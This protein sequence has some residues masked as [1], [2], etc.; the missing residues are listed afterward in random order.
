MKVSMEN[1]K[2]E[3]IKRM[4]A[5]DIYAEAIRH[6]AYDGTLN[7]SEPPLGM[8][9]WL[10][11]KQKEIVKKFEEEYNALVYFGI[12]SYT[13]FGTWDSFLFV[14][15]YKEEWE[16]DNHIIKDGEV[17]AYVYNYD[18]PEYSEMG[19]IGVQQIFGGLVRIW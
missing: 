17:Y 19:C 8:N 9:Y 5:L 6:F 4:Y 11:D 18:V 14:S 1:K 13:N 10:D 12:R 2:R 3:A 7:Y 16:M 15:D